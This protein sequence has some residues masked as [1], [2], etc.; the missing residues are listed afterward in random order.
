M[1][2]TLTLFALMMTLL[3]TGCGGKRETREFDAW[4]RA[5]G[6]R[7]VSFSAHITAERP[8]GTAS[9]DAEIRRI[10]DETAV[11]VTAPATIA[12]ITVRSR[13]GS[14]TLEYDGMILELAAGRRDALSPCAA[15][16]ILLSALREGY[17]LS[18]G[19]AGA[20]E[21]WTLSAPGEETVTVWRDGTNTPVSAE[22]ARDGAVELKLTM[23]NW[24]TTERT[25]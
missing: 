2:R 24:Q 6:A 7:N 14:D 23:E 8:D 13:D 5:F 18:A 16:E 12:G 3:L 22:I 17:L 9:Y 25:E 10:G 1:R 19:K 20:L 11:T 21:T 4:Q 15:G